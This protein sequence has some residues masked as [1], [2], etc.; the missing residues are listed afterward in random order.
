MFTPWL[1]KDFQKL[2]EQHYNLLDI[3]ETKSFDCG[4]IDLLIERLLKNKKSVYEVNDRYV[5]VQFDTDFYWHGHGI[6]LN[7]LF[8]VWRSLDIPLYTMLFYTNHFGIGQEIEQLCSWADSVDR[9]TV[10][11][12]FINPGNYNPEYT[13]IPVNIDAIDTHALCMMAGSQRSHRHAVYNALKELVPAK[14]EM[15]LKS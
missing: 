5:I 14:I 3:I 15:T 11:E 4:K 6:N 7:N 1:D 9:P 8:T 10:I 13:N 12:T 2:L